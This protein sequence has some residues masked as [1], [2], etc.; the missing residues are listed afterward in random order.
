MSLNMRT[1]YLLLV[2]AMTAVFQV[3][4]AQQTY[5]FLRVRDPAGTNRRRQ[6]RC[7][8]SRVQKGCRSG[9]CSLWPGIYLLLQRRQLVG[10]R[11]RDV[12]ER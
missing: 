8:H 5:R 1:A 4:A 12:G 9:W 7:R 2:F 3:A 6:L 11:R 10:A